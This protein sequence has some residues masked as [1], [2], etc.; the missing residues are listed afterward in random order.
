MRNVNLSIRA[1]PSERSLFAYINT[2]AHC[3]ICH[4]WTTFVDQ[5][6]SQLET[7]SIRFW[8]WETGRET[9]LKELIYD[10]TRLRRRLTVKVRHH[11]EIP[12]VVYKEVWEERWGRR[13]LVAFEI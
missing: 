10:T 2:H 12:V 11:R 9:R 1:P 6:D 4:L 5:S 3:A 13:V 8:R 7:L